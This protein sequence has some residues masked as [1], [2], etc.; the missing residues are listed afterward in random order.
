MRISIYAL[1]IVIFGSPAFAQGDRAP[2]L[3]F[4][5]LKLHDIHDKIREFFN[6]IS[7]VQC[8]GTDEPHINR[9]NSEDG[10]SSFT[11]KLLVDDTSSKV[12][13]DIEDELGSSQ[14]LK[15]Q[16][17]SSMETWDYEAGAL[18]ELKQVLEK[19]NLHVPL[20]VSS[21]QIS[22]EL[23]SAITS[24]TLE[25]FLRSAYLIKLRGVHNVN[26]LHT[27]WYFLSAKH[28]LLQKRKTIRTW[29]KLRKHLGQGFRIE[30]DK[31]IY[32]IICKQVKQKINEDFATHISKDDLSI[33]IKKTIMM[34]EKMTHNLRTGSNIKAI[35]RIL[36]KFFSNYVPE[37]QIESLVKLLNK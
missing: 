8:E 29:N 15:N 5:Y 26:I 14:E 17:L 30:L 34:S 23:A 3:V 6:N 7:E 25:N 20:I 24:M 35:E 16:F 37:D 27:E 18:H 31:L 13:L 22:M 11:F 1:F 10:E 32:Q 33:N 4:T 9:V 2:D 12:C 21:S 36:A 28:N 19:N